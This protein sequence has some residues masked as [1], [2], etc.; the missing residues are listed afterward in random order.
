MTLVRARSGEPAIARFARTIRACAYVITVGVR[1]RAFARRGA[2]K[3]A[4]F[5][6]GLSSAVLACAVLVMGAPSVL[7]DPP[8][9]LPTAIPSGYFRVE[10]RRGVWW[11]IDPRG[12]PTLSI[13]VDNVVH[14]GD[15]IRGTGPSPYLQAVEQIYPDR[16]AWDRRAV[17][18]LRAWGFNTLGAW[19]DAELTDQHT[20]YTV[21]LDFAARSGADW[22]HGTPVDV[23]D[24]RFEDTAREIASREATLRAHDPMLIGYFSDNEL[25]WGSD[26]RRRGTMLASYLSLPV[27]APGRKRAIEFLQMRYG[28]AQRLSSA[29][30]VTV[31]DFAHVPPRAS[32]RAYRADADAFLETVASRYFAL[33]ARVIRA[34]DRHHLYLGARFAGV[35]PD[36]VLRASWQVDVVSINLYN[37]DPRPAVAHV[38]AMTGRPVLVSEFSFRALDSGFPN[39]IGAGPWVFSQWGRARAYERYVFGLERLPAAIGYH[40]FRWADEPREGRADGENSN[41]GLVSLTDTPYAE[42]VTAITA[43]NRAAVHVHRG[44]QAT[45]AIAGQAPWQ[46]WH[47]RAILDTLLGSPRWLVT[48]IRTLSAFLARA[49]L[50]LRT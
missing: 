7:L 16:S 24:P 22:L 18:R 28:S 33:S 40:W 21:I 5:R 29:W 32:T 27:D 20:P 36:P 26:W 45:T 10:N 41:Y 1:R 37:R 11:L 48:A 43:A 34:A 6:A 14:A 50:A 25:W 44:A 31:P 46:T 30:H 39:T 35:P 23:Y 8:S 49:P 15:R 19:S 12:A 3:L 47:L 38:F 13:G 42:F 9:P 17:D 4:W 2:E